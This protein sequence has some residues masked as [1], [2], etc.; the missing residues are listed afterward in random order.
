[1]SAP[2]ASILPSRINTTPFSIVS[3]DT[4]MILAPWIASGP[5]A[6]AWLAELTHKQPKTIRVS[7]E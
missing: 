4:V 3:P 6:K 7:A 5:A 1:M 2:T